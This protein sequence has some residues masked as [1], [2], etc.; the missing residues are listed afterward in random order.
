MFTNSYPGLIE[1]GRLPA[2]LQYIIL[3]CIDDELNRRYQ[4]VGELEN[5][6]NNYLMSLNPA[7]NPRNEYENLLN[8]A[9]AN[10]NQNIYD[11]DN[12]ESLIQALFF[13]VVILKYF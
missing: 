10:S 5:A 7:S 2:G 6:L 8:I 12:L 13:L 3:K 4:S 9:K 11:K 1:R